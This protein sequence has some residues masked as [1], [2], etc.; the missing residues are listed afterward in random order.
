MPSISIFKGIRVCMYY[1]DN[2][3]HKL[4]HVHVECQ[5]DKAVF[6]IPNGKILSGEIKPNKRKFMQ[7]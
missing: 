6:S 2:D 1:R 7:E 4:P 3:K 5:G